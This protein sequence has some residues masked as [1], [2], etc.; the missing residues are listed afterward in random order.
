VPPTPVRAYSLPLPHPPRRQAPGFVRPLPPQAAPRRRASEDRRAPRDPGRR[1]ARL[2]R[3]G[4]LYFVNFLVIASE[5]SNLASLAH[6]VA[7]ECF[8][9]R[10]PHDPNFTSG[11]NFL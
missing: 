10:A 7:R 2:A 6:G 11:R 9:L 4:K 3:L 1:G 8:A 5:A